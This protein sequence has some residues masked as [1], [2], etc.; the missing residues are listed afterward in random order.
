MM[1]CLDQKVQLDRQE[2]IIY[3]GVYADRRLWVTSYADAHRSSNSQAIERRPIMSDPQFLGSQDAMVGTTVA[4]R[5]AIKA[6]VGEGGMG[7]VYKAIQEPIG[8]EVAVKVLLMH[9]VDDSLKLQRFVNEARIL[10]GLRHPHTVSLID[11]GRLRDGRLYIVMDYVH[12]GALRDLMDEGRLHQV[13]ALRITRQILQSLAEAHAHGII[14]RDLKP[15]NV[16]LD[17]VESE[18]FV[19]RVADFGIAK[20]DSIDRFVGISQQTNHKNSDFGPTAHVATSPGIRLGTPAYI[21]PE[22]AF[23]KDIDV[24]TDLYSVGIILFEMLTGHKPFSSDTERGLCLE[25][26]H[27]APKPINSVNT[28]LDIDPKVEELLLTLM[29]KDRDGRP[30]SAKQVIKVID[31]VLARLAPAN[32]GKTVPLPKILP[33]VMR[34]ESPTLDEPIEI[35]RKLPPWAIGLMGGLVVGALLGWLL[36]SAG[37]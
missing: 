33:A 16:L 3:P 17:S 25:H 10:S 7:T 30:Q 19:I 23:A 4:E 31:R 5:Y 35:G 21:A 13:A 32:H 14:H 24:R 26:L 1:D 22:Q 27:T 8:R 6:V 9:L 2:R 18:E 29:A 28:Q 36:I 34:K 11:C 15:E 12:G 37:P 20:L